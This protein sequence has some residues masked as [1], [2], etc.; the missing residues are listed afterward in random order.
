MEEQWIRDRARLRELLKEHPGWT[1]AQLAEELGYSVSWVKKWC[2]RLAL[3]DPYDMQVLLSRSRAHRSPYPSWDP[4][5]EQ[6]IVEM[7][8]EPPEKL[9]RVPGPKALLYYLPRDPELKALGVPLPRSSRT[10]WKILRKNG[11]LLAPFKAEKKPLEPKEPLEEVQTDF[12]DIT[13]VAASESQEGKRQ[14][15]VEVCNFVDAGTSILRCQLWLGAIF[16][17][18]RLLRL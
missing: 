13:T 3:A 12:K 6:R 11:C 1:K 9:H 10:V 8:L 18:K 5:V 17:L 14:H 4:R 2:K 16:T 15:V 7:R